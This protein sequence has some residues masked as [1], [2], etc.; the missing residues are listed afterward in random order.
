MA[1]NYSGHGSSG[2]F[3][4]GNTEG[5]KQL[6]FGVGNLDFLNNE[7]SRVDRYWRAIE[8]GSDALLGRTLGG[9]WRST[10]ALPGQRHGVDLTQ[11]G[12]GAGQQFVPYAHTMDLEGALYSAIRARKIMKD[13]Q[14]IV[15]AHTSGI[16]SKPIQA[17]GDYAKAFRSFPALQEE[18]AVLKTLI[19]EM[20]R[21]GGR[22]AN[23]SRVNFANIPSFM[24]IGVIS[25][26]NLQRLAAARR[27]LGNQ[28]T[29]ANRELAI[30]LQKVVV[31]SLE[32]KRPDVSTGRL[33]DAYNDPRNRFPQ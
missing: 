28:L 5:L 33:H 25:K 2:L 24:A 26:P 1:G 17:K 3:E 23:V 13:Q 8:N 30:R 6:G 18:A 21:S 14:G 10:G 31:D 27:D 32:Y 4:V 20:A 16:I 22:A 7:Q 19:G 11:F 29:N 15:N 12:E 9:G